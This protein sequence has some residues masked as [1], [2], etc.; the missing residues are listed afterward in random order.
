[1][2]WLK[3]SKLLRVA[4]IHSLWTNSLQLKLYCTVQALWNLIGAFRFLLNIEYNFYT[5]LW[6]NST[7][8]YHCV[9]TCYSL[10][11]HCMIEWS[12]EEF[13]LQS[14]QRDGL[15]LKLR[16][17]IWFSLAWYGDVSSSDEHQDRFAFCA[18]HL[19][20]E[21]LAVNKKSIAVATP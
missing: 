21:L 6:Y 18:M 14:E 4:M 16:E 8:G 17:R 7:I 15:G 1:M 11:M 9:I 20:C 10:F 19:Q 12:A 2:F 13:Y 5:P 3:P